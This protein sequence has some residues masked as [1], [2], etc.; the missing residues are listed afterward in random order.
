MIRNFT[1]LFVA[2]AAVI[3]SCGPPS[4]KQEATAE[5]GLDLSLMDTTADPANNFYRFANGGW[6]DKTEI[7]ADRGSWGA[8]DELGKKTSERVH[9]ILESTI[10]SGSFDPATDQGKAAVF[11]QVAMDTAHID[12]LGIVPIAD[13][14]ARIDAIRDFEE[15]EAYLIAS[16]PLQTQAFFSLSARPSLSDS[17][18][19]A[20]FLNEGQLGLPGK[21]YYVKDDEET[22]RLQS[23]YKAFVSKVLQLAGASENEAE[24][25]TEAIFE[26]E[27][28]LAEGQLDKVQKRNPLLMN[29]PRSQDQIAALAPSFDW[30]GYFTA[31]GLAETDTFIVMQPQY[32]EALE[33]TFTEVP[34]E[35]LKAYTKWTALNGALAYLSSDFEKA[36]F[37][38]YNGVLGGVEEMQPRWERV[39]STIG[40]S[41]GEALGKLYVDEYFPPE[42]KQVAEELVNNLKAAFKDRINA[43]EWMSDSTKEKALEK[44]ARL[45]VKIGYPDEWKD[46]SALVVKSKADGGSYVGNMIEVS[47]WDWRRKI[48]KIGQ[49]VDK[50]EWFMPPQMV[51]AYYHPLYNE[52]V[53][54]AAILQ[55]PYYNYKADPA[56]NYGGIGAVIG[57]EIS[58]GFDDQ[59]SRF[60]AQGNLS[61]WWTEED[62]TR[63][64]E[65]TKQLTDQ[66][67]IYEPLPGVFVNGEFT[68]GENIGDLGGV[69]VA[70]DALQKHLAEH[71]DP[72]LIDGFSQS[73]R[74]FLN[75]ATVWRSKYRDEAMK[76]QVKTNVHSPGQYRAIGPVINLPA[77]QDAFD[78]NEGDKM[79]KPDSAMV[80]IW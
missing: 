66:Y 16:S 1:I 6:L 33:A 53:F 79:Y 55:P 52:I 4:P 45:R 28:R 35:K 18:V 37:D 13:E 9:G 3:F 20:G 68:L 58:H 11:Y 19:N 67:S 57:H 41:I 62:R 76:K 72:G 2:L 17:D 5:P 8:F 23:E 50:S 27:K 61:N 80:V 42:A 30:K 69:A 49:P 26:V 70:Y 60:D 46:Y 75:W 65:R 25:S 40:F 73:Q 48:D 29:N 63:F 56:V 54:P 15:L 21:E 78:V 7:P 64:E 39:L 77:F 47:K 38:F 12:Q 22:L 43:L 34:L 59:G 31:I 32:M 71:G 74:F 10:A 44:L 36:N 51:N 14:L 24:A